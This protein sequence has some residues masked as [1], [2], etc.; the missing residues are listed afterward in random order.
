MGLKGIDSGNDTLENSADILGLDPRINIGLFGGF[1]SAITDPRIG[2]RGEIK[3]VVMDDVEM[4]HKTA[5]DLKKKAQECLIKGEIKN[6]MVYFDKWIDIEPVEGR[7]YKGVILATFDPAKFMDGISEIAEAIS[8]S[9]NFGN[10]MTLQGI[11]D[12][13]RNNLIFQVPKTKINT[14]SEGQIRNEIELLLGAR[15][16]PSIQKPI[17]GRLLLFLNAYLNLNSIDK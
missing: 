14:G 11:L 8:L 5:R 3:G 7:I 17:T 1:S 4:P 16:N 12:N 6:A 13:G 10:L 15:G 2:V 9:F